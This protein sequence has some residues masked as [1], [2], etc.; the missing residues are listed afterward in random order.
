LKRH[1]LQFDGAV[2]DAMHMRRAVR[3]RH[4]LG[5]CD[6][7]LLEKPLRP[8]P[9]PTAADLSSTVVRSRRV[10]LTRSLSGSGLEDRPLH[11]RDRTPTIQPPIRRGAGAS[12]LRHPA[13]YVA[14]RLVKWKRDRV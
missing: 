1:V 3:A 11:P 6:R 8:H 14:E 4:L 5:H 7:D 10:A 13:L 12:V 2:N 9:G